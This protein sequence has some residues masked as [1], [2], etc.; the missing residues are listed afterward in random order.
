MI[1]WLVR[2][3]LGKA[4]NWGLGRLAGLT[5]REKARAAL[6]GGDSFGPMSLDGRVAAAL[7]QLLREPLLPAGIAQIDVARTWLSS[8]ETQK[9]LTNFLLARMGGNGALA[10]RALEQLAESYTEAT[11]EA[12]QLAHGQ[13]EAVANYAATLLAAE[14]SFLASQVFELAADNR[15]RRQAGQELPAPGAL[16]EVAR[17]L[18]D[19]VPKAAMLLKQRIP[20][21]FDMKSQ[22]GMHER[23]DV[24]AL[25]SLL[26]TR[27]LVV[28]EGEG[29]IGKTTALVELG[30]AM[31]AG[32]NMP[33]PLYVSAVNWRLSGLPLLGYVAGFAGVRRNGTDETA[34][35]R[36]LVAGKVALL[37]NGWNE[38]SAT[39]KSLAVAMAEDFIGGHPNVMVACT[40]RRAEGPFA[41]ASGSVVGVVEFNWERQRMLIERALPRE[42][43]ERLLGRLQSDTTLRLTARNPLV[44]SSAILL[45]Q[46]GREVPATLYGLLEAVQP[47]LESSAQRQVALSDPPLN[48]QHRTYLK[49]LAHCLTA[50]GDI[51]MS[52]DKAQQTVGA[53]I[54]ELQRS[55]HQFQ[56]V[57]VEPS[58]IVEALCDTHLLH[59]DQATGNLRFAHQK[60]QEFFAATWVLDRIS[61]EG[62]RTIE[63]LRVLSKDV[64]NWPAWTEVLDL[65]AEKLA[66]S[67]PL[68]ARSQLIV[69]ALRADLTLASELAGAVQMQPGEGG[70]FLQLKESIVR[71]H[72]ASAKSAK[73]HAIAC[74]ALTRTAAFAPEL[75][76]VIESTD[77]REALG[78]FNDVG[79][80]SVRS[81]GDDLPDRFRSWTPKQRRTFVSRLGSFSENLPFLT[82][83]ACRDA[84]PAV[85]AQGITTLAWEFPA[86]DAGLDAWFAA[87]DE[88]KVAHDSFHSILFLVTAERMPRLIFEVQR[89][90]KDLGDENL[91]LQL[92]REVPLE[93]RGFALEAAKQVLREAHVNRAPNDETVQLVASFDSAALLAI[94]EEQLKQ[95]RIAPDWVAAHLAAL[96]AEERRASFSRVFTHVSGRSADDVDGARIGTLAG[97]DDVAVVFREWIDL[98]Q[99]E[100]RDRERERLLSRVLFAASTDDLAAAVLAQKAETDPS[101]VQRML[102][103]LQR[104]RFVERSTDH[105]EEERR[106]L[107][108]AAARELLEAF[109]DLPESAEIPA[110]GVK[111]ILCVLLSRAD[112]VLFEGQIFEGLMLEVARRKAVAGR[113]AATVAVAYGGEFERAAMAC[114]TSMARRL[115]PMF[116]PHDESYVLL[117]VLHEIAIQPWRRTTSQSQ[118]D[119]KARQERL[120]EGLVQSQRDVELQ[121]ITDELATKVAAMLEACGDAELSPRENR[122]YRRWW[123][124]ALL[125]RLPTTVGWAELRKSLIRRDAPADRFT[126]TL[127]ALVSQGANIEDERLVGALMTKFKERVESTAWFDQQD[128]SLGD[129]AALHFFVSSDLFTAADLDTAVDLW[130][131]KAQSYVVVRKLRDLGSH[132]AMAQLTRLSKQGKF[133]NTNDALYALMQNPEGPRLMLD[134]TEDGSLFHL[135]EGYEGRRQVASVLAPLIGGNVVLLHKI[136]D[137]C[138][139]QGKAAGEELAFEL[140]SALP[141]PDTKALDYLL[142]YVDRADRSGGSYVVNSLPNLFEEREP[143]EGSP[144]THHLFPRACNYVRT[145][146][147]EMAMTPGP[148]AAVAAEVLLAIEHRR[149]SLGRPSNEP[150]HP[151]IDSE[152]SWPQDLSSA[153]ER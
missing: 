52:F 70:P 43:A 27:R 1:E 57:G 94:A 2:F 87:P 28:I 127:N 85:S 150:R 136:L 137:V 60:F 139:R 69:L 12:L 50:S 13:V 9:A 102:E 61:A 86:S 116:D 37:L 99:S 8:A 133:E 151:N 41:A 91:L 72:A 29:G 120:S 78:L 128:T 90:T 17:D 103:V 67:G 142:E 77:R 96:G 23:L 132:A 122:F 63:E 68:L 20:A 105:A 25:L 121:G 22:R 75:F 118:L 112:P 115:L 24:E 40:S 146:L 3:V 119:I 82:D 21:V 104:S 66:A 14:P 19:Q 148:T 97:K 101:R 39:G 49:A 55:H 65:A 48:S 64:F 111:A 143:V 34:L 46:E 141:A 62:H 123:L 47:I 56:G 114:G 107:A 11:G 80:V 36:L 145:R 71:L 5:Q 100:P 126:D 113:R 58:R 153:L 73:R 88:V 44:L 33:V 54:V 135:L 106:T 6:K 84:D 152:H 30:H 15:E 109:W 124:M 35:S 45:A 92:A 7:D 83:I 149:F 18:L 110:H 129:L 51:V 76:A 130:A 89:L 131:S 53:T 125:A 81:F 79:G 59:R 26:Q 10:A 98:S 42:A 140:V 117:A 144:N 147:F 4:S 16:A 93:Q 134:M 138:A 108:P 95:Q 74:M 31:L 32:A 38:I